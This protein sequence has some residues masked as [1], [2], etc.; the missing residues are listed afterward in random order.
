MDPVMNIRAGEAESG[1][2]TIPCLTT[3]GRC[4][5]R[6]VAQPTATDRYLFNGTANDL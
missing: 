4:G 5:R 3:L 2:S 6:A 1:I